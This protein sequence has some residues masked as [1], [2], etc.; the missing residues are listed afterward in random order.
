MFLFFVLCA[1]GAREKGSSQRGCAA[2]DSRNSASSSSV[3]LSTP[4]SLI[5]LTWTAVCSL[6][7]RKKLWRSSCCEPLGENRV[8]TRWPSSVAILKGMLSNGSTKQIPTSVVNRLQFEE[9]CLFVQSKLPELR[10]CS[11]RI[12]GAEEKRLGSPQ[13]RS[14]GRCAASRA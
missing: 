10:P 14:S 3:P 4:K 12:H 5:S 8:S 1:E 11:L 6:I 9:I 13:A 7:H 2:R